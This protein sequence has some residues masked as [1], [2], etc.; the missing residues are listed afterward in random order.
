MSSDVVPARVRLGRAKSALPVDADPRVIALKEWLRDCAGTTSWTEVAAAASYS[1][2]AVSTALGGASLPKLRVVLAI[3]A[4]VGA[5][6]TTTRELWVAAKLA[7]YQ[8]ATPTPATP[9]GE[10]AGELRVAMARIDVGATQL[11]QRMRKLAV[12]TG[13]GKEPMSR[14]TLHRFLNGETLPRLGQVGLLLRCLEMG[15]PQRDQL[16]RR[17][18]VI[19]AAIAITK[20]QSSGLGRTPVVAA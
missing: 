4:A 9:L 2:S 17:C 13:Y 20:S 1:I 10:L 19:Q 7:E 3:A 11:Q 8:R 5:A 12:T 6:D 15:E 14:A 16:L 18:E